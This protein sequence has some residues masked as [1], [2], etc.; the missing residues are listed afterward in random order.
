MPGGDAMGSVAVT[1]NHV[2][3]FIRA[4]IDLQAPPPPFGSHSSRSR[5]QGS[6]GKRADLRRGVG[7]RCRALRLRQEVHRP[8]ATPS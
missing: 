5:T 3:S 7:R 2:F 6:T 8:P 4:E 1:L